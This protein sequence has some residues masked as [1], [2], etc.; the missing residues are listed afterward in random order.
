[1]IY[2]CLKIIGKIRKQFNFSIAAVINR[3]KKV[4]QDIE[5]NNNLEVNVEKQKRKLRKSFFTEI[6]FDEERKFIRENNL[7]NLKQLNEFHLDNVVFKGHHEVV[8]GWN[9][10][11]DINSMIPLTDYTTYGSADDNPYQKILK[12]FSGGT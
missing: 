7:I 4:Q 12:I 6:N 9:I 8:E 3:E 2:V 5:N 11:D 1:M 10:Y